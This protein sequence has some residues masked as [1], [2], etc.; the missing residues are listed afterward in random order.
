VRLTPI[1]DP[2]RNRL[3]EL[4]ADKATY[5]LRKVVAVDKLFVDAGNGFVTV[6]DEYGNTIDFRGSDFVRVKTNS[7]DRLDAGL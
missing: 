4:F 7:P 6:A 2:D 1:R 3:R 5:E